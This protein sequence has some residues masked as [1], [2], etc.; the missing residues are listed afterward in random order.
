MCT[1]IV[2]VS[3]SAQDLQ[4]R[5]SLERARQDQHNETQMAKRSV[6]PAL[7]RYYN[8][9]EDGF[10]T[11][12]KGSSFCVSSSAQAAI[13]TVEGSLLKQ[14]NKRLQEI[15]KLD[16]SVA[17][18]AN[19]LLSNRP[20]GGCF[21]VVSG[22]TNESTSFAAYSVLESMGVVRTLP[23]MPDTPQCIPVPEYEDL[24]IRY[25]PMSSNWEVRRW[26]FDKGPVLASLGLTKDFIDNYVRAPNTISAATNYTYD[27][28]SPSQILGFQYFSSLVP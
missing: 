9:A 13:A 12:V 24:R 14:N 6:V 16:F 22:S 11:S 23:A 1:Y 10:I 4:L 15:G 19:C 26:I 17:T 21:N 7:P 18:M 27:V 2:V 3:E 20:S 25:V 5:Q 28:A 8:L